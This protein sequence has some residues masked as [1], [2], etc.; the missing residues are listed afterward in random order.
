MWS[1]IELSVAVIVICLPPSRQVWR[2][3]A[4][5]VKKRPGSRPLIHAPTSRDLSLPSNLV[6]AP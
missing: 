2:E 1:Y 3:L 6:S 4:Q 5:K